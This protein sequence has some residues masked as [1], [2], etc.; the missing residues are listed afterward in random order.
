VTSGVVP[1]SAPARPEQG[2]DL[3]F[4]MIEMVPEDVAESLG[5]HSYAD[6]AGQGGIDGLDGRRQAA[7]LGDHEVKLVQVLGVGQVIPQHGPEVVV[8]GGVVDLQGLAEGGPALGRGAWPAVHLFELGGEGLEAGRVTAQPGMDGPHEAKVGRAVVV[9]GLRT[10]PAPPNSQ[11][12]RTGR[13]DQEQH[14]RWRST[15]CPRHE[16]SLLLDF[17]A[18]VDSCS[19]PTV[20][21]EDGARPSTSPELYQSVMITTRNG[22]G[23]LHSEP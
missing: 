10:P 12:R 4:L 22:S 5:G 7:V 2:K 11:D 9:A 6:A 14:P 21:A 18:S 23:Q 16:G 13:D 15:C 17:C 3:P 19:T 20:E 1:L 8:F